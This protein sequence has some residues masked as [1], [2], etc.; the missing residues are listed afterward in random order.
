M[1]VPARFAWRCHRSRQALRGFTLVEVLVI[2]VIIGIVS[3]VVLLSLGVLG[4]DRS[5]QQ[6]ARRISSLIELASDEALMQGRDFGIEFTRTGYRFLELDSL[7]NQWHA[8][9]GDELLRPRQ[10]EEQLELALVLEDRDVTLGEEFAATE[11]TE[12]KDADDRDNQTLGGDYQP[13]VLILSSGDVSPFVLH[14]Q[15]PSDRTEIVVD[16]GPTGEMEIQTAA[17]AAR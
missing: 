9:I 6:Q 2:V 10:L 17:E 7:T 12:D 8:V 5:L 3:A 14:I 11:S 13:H 16:M 4:D 15:R 1:G